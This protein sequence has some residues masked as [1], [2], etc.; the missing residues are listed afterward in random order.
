[1]KGSLVLTTVALVVVAPVLAG[2]QFTATTTAEYP[3]GA[4]GFVT[5]VKGVADG[6]K[7][8]VD[9]V[10]ST[11]QGLTV[12][13]WF[14]STDGGKTVTL[15]R[16][17]AGTYG[18]WQGEA[19]AGRT[20]RGE[21]RPQSGEGRPQS[22]AHGWRVVAPRLEKLEAGKDERLF[23]HGTNHYKFRVTYTREAPIMRGKYLLTT[24]VVQDEELWTVADISDSGVSTWLT[25]PVV[26][27]GDQGADKEISGAF[28]SIEGYPVK[29]I[30]TTTVTEGGRDPEVTRIVREL[31]SLTSAH[32]PAESLVM[33]AGLTRQEAGR[34]GSGE[35]RPPHRPR[36]ASAGE[37]P[38]PGLRPSAEGQKGLGPEAVPKVNL[39]TPAATA[40]PSQ[41]V[42]ATPPPA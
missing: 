24:K 25:K 19:G 8:R 26:R 42:V 34:G 23:G 16:P 33:P 4:P 14:L 5:K 18:S 1:M 41:P 37:T 32:V 12:G 3:A 22:S 15:I 21:R 11:E 30:T 27:T 29:R 7:G 35:G 6:E 36:P 28:G 38:G 2:T 40:P 17:K 13:D 9:I 31:T 39:T 20:A 10:E